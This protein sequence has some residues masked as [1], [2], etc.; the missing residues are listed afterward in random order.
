MVSSVLH[1]T[2]TFFPSRSLQTT[3]II[4]E[5]PGTGRRHNLVA[6]QQSAAGAYGEPEAEVRSRKRPPLPRCLVTPVA[7]SPGLRRGAGAPDRAGGPCGPVEGESEAGA[8]PSSL[9]GVPFAVGRHRELVGTLEGPGDS[10]EGWVTC[11]C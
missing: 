11:R 9:V 7:H 10:G 2:R 8:G 5:S 6:R 1:L 4:L 3:S